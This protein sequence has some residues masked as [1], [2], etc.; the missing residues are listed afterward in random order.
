M[1]KPQRTAPLTAP[2]IS[3]DRLACANPPAASRAMRSP[4]VKRA[5]AA[6]GKVCTAA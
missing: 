6:G 1:N 4:V 2:L 3:A 5:K